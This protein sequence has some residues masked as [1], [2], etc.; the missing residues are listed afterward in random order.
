MKL[1]EEFVSKTLEQIHLENKDLISFAGLKKL[2][3]GT[4]FTHLP[5]YKKRQK[6]MGFRWNLYRLSS[7]RG[8][9]VLI[10]THFETVSP[11]Y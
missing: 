2:L 6:T 5:I 11:I 10:G 4:T 3:Y 7:L 9:G 1:R 8:V